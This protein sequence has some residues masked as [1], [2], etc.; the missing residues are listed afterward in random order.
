M[1]TFLAPEL[2]TPILPCHQNA[3][4]VSCDRQDRYLCNDAK[5]GEYERKVQ[6]GL[7]HHK[8]VTSYTVYSASGHALLSLLVSTFCLK[9]K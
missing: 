9:S 7:M 6:V 2:L 5:L 4:R 3:Q 8:Q 1:Y